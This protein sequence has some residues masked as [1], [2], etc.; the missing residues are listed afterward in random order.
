MKCR[1]LSILL[2]CCLMLA[3]TPAVS[4]ASEFSISEGVFT[5]LTCDQSFPFNISDESNDLFIS[6]SEGL[7]GWRLPDEITLDN[8]SVIT[9]VNEDG[10]DDTNYYNKVTGKVHIGAAENDYTLISASALQEEII[11]TVII[12]PV[13]LP[14]ITPMAPTETEIEE[15]ETVQNVKPL[16]L[17]KAVNLGKS[18]NLSWTKVD[19]ADRY[20]VYS[21]T[22][23]VNNAFERLLAT[24]SNTLTA[25]KINCASGKGYKFYVAAYS[26]DKLMA[27]SFSAHAVCGSRGG[28][29]NAASIKAAEEELSIKVG[30][31][32][33]LT[34]AVSPLRGKLFYKGHTDKVRFVSSDNSIAAVSGTGSVKGIKAGSCTVYAIAPNGLRCSVR[35]LVK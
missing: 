1:I 15:S 24:D 28:C 4:G 9:G 26:G 11:E 18:I 35:I 29:Y 17:L 30:E 34:V 6:V 27:K 12:Y 5:N 23:G 25:K 33:G 31:S 2:A 22:C 20:I 3:V 16:I 14:Y 19:G 8:T 21:N 7:S 13:V 32:H 10:A